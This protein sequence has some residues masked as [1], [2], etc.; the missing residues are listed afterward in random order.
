MAASGF[1]AVAAQSPERRALVDPSEAVFTYGDLAGTANQISRGL[2]AGRIGPGDTVA[3]MLP[4]S[5]Q[6]LALHAAAAQIGATFVVVNWHLTADEVSYILAD[7][8]ARLVVTDDRFAEV[9]ASAAD[10]A[11]VPPTQRF[12]VGSASGF[13][14][15]AELS[16]GQSSRPLMDRSAGLVL[17][18]TSGTTGRPK[19][20][21]KHFG[22]VPADEIG[23]ATPIGLRGRAPYD[24]AN[25]EVHIV[26]GPLYHAA[27]L[28]NAAM[29]LDAGALL[30]LMDHWTAERWLDLVTRYRV[31][32]SAMVPTM[33]HRLLMLPDATRAATDVSSLRSV[34]HA[35][36]PCA[37]ELK[38]RMLE[39]LGPII[40]ES[41]SSTEGAGTSVT[42]EEW[43]A[44]PGTVGRPS[45]G[46]ILKILDDDGNECPPR[47]EGLVYLSTALWEFEYQ[48]D[49]DK[50]EA[51]R[52]DG[53]F[54]VGDIGYVDEDGYLFLCD[55]QAEV[56]IS[57]GVNIYPAEVEAVLGEH[58]AVGDVAVVGVPDD[59]W[60]EAVR[61][62]VEPAPGVI[63]SP[64]LERELVQW[65]RDQLAHFKC[66]RRI[67]FV[68]ALG[69]DPN[70]KV[71]KAQIRARYWDPGSRR[72]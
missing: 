57:G 14:D 42:A 30:V 63:P 13:R 11:D 70:G 28:A 58:V 49:P 35:G 39:W 24:P 72:I 67:D 56:I 36:A 16:D 31:T 53:L 9:I 10:A 44:R 20:V 69:R 25:D 68:D 59:E 40:T 65:S 43:L 46:V 4:N 8:A 47:T 52:R 45:P 7:S 32:N 17:F 41:Y 26:G 21:R 62:V 38:Q 64:E 55:R 12:T 1:F 23:L 22:S 54:T 50:T 6:L 27:P 60:G 15:F 37:V 33:F 61:A 71:R 51:A 2:R 48:H 29:A 3:A 18:Y 34:S 19:G 5:V 66:P